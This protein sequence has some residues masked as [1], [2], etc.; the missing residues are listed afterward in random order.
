MKVTKYYTIEELNKMSVQVAKKKA[1]A[2]GIPRTPHPPQSE[3]TH[4]I[5]ITPDCSN[6]RTVNDWHWTSGLPVYKDICIKCHN[7][8][9]AGK[10]G[11][12]RISQ[13]VAKNAGFDTESEYLDHKAREEGF[14]SQYDK[15]D[16]LAKQ[17]GFASQYDKLDHKAREEGF[18]SHYD[19]IDQQA[20]QQGFASHYDKLDHKA[21]EEGFASHYDKIDQQAKQQ[22]FASH[23]DKLDHK[24]RE[25]GFASH[26]DKLERKAIEEG[27]L[28]L[29]DKRNSTHPFRK[30]R[31]DYCENIDNR[32]GG[33][34][35]TTTIPLLNGV[36]FVGILDVDHIDGNPDNNDQSN[37]QTLCKCC[38]AYKTIKFKDYE[39]PGR[40]A[41]KEEQRRLKE[42]EQQKSNISYSTS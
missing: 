30:W 27:Y 7:K 34:A 39:S 31:K 18:A 12:T 13:V 41:L 16:Q 6:P 14:A 20:K 1:T 17:Q 28:S 19:K 2:Q 23:Y 36:P 10:H 9:V 37:A 42:Q 29:T 15:L 8:A 33:G 26:Y 4:P 32:L 5:C 25:E 38:H 3:F 35:C 21:R 11:L 40:G 24:A 22:G